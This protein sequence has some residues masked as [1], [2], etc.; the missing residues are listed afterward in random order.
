MHKTL[1]A[2]LFAITFASIA[3][4]Q[5]TVKLEDPPW[6][7]EVASQRIV[8]SLPGMENIKARKD[9]VYKRAA[10][11]E[12]KLD[13]YL[14]P[15]LARG[16]RRPA[17]IF[18]HGGALPPNLLT[19]PKEWGAYVSFGQLAAA[20]GFVGVVLNHRFH[21]WDMKGLSIADDDVVEAIDYVD[22]NAE[23]LGVDTKHITLWTLSAGSLVIGS[24]ISD[25]ASQIRC[26]VFYYPI[27]EL[28]PLRKDRPTI[29]DDAVKEFSVIRHLKEATNK[30]T[31]IFIAR[32]G[33]EEPG[34]ND[35]LDSFIKE[36]LAKKL[37]LDFSNHATGQHGFDVLDNDDRSREII[38]RTLEFVKANG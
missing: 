4:T 20:S 6:I 24:A 35:A 27:M 33:R 21:S 9:L 5:E 16:T 10:E 11:D 22:R 8:Y 12:L 13:V 30:S 37:T 2:L 19:Q 32:A 7:K 28:E 15:N 14:P 25:P 17:I 38:K 29:T 34:I 26:L 31:A 18:I 36:A 1:A 23:Q 3:I